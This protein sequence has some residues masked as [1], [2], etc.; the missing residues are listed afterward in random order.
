MAGSKAGMVYT[1][2]PLMNGMVIAPVDWGQGALA[3]LHDQALVQ[4]NHR[5]MA[6][7][8]LVLTTVYAVQ[9][10]PGEAG[11][12]RRGLGVGAAGHGV[13]PGAAGRSPP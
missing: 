6:Y 7:G 3:F 11:A 1:D 9:A 13:G 10:D 8:L 5:I 2:W 12:G 4:F